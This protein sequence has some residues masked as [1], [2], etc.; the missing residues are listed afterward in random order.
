[1]KLNNTVATFLKSSL[2]RDASVGLRVLLFFDK[3][4]LAASFR[5]KHLLQKRN[6]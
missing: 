4:A 6:A 1:M 3:M 5:E 2:S